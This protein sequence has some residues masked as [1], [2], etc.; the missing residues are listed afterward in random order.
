MS[1]SKDLLESIGHDGATEDVTYENTQARLRTTVLMNY[2]NSV[3]GFVE[4]TGDM[5]ESAVGWCTFNGDHMSMFNPN[6][7]VPKT[8]VKHL[9]SWYAENRAEP[10]L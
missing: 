10:R 2:A 4:G 6:S 5:S 7:A 3:H 9:V 8:L 1:L